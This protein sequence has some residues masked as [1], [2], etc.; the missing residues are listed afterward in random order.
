MPDIRYSVIIP[1]NNE[2]EA[3]EPLVCALIPIM[4]S[5]AATYE[6]LVIDDGSTDGTLARLNRVRSRTPH[7]TLLSFPT[8]Q[9][10]GSALQAG[11]DR[12][13]GEIVITLDGDLQN[14]P[15][16]IPHL[17]KKLEEGFDVVC[18]WRFPRRDPWMKRASS[19]VANAVRRMVLRETVHDVGCALRVFR[20]AALHA[21]DLSDGKHRWFTW[22][23][24][25]AGCRIGEVKVR[26][27]PRR[28]GRSHYGTWDRFVESCATLW[29]LR[30]SKE[31]DRY[32]SAV[33]R[34]RRPS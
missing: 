3:I 31:R 17:L 24:A 30:Q 28:F 20:R 23:A 4:E 22:L 21:I 26:H 32:E 14:D 18:G 7:M 10:Q 5:L 29:R 13:R 2:E 16:G 9:G 8:R 1:V 34:T 11:L 12:A 25:R 6:L 15:G 19:G 33:D 27:H